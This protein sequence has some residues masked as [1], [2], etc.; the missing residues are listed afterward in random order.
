MN[1]S[2]T[3]S[4]SQSGF[5]LLERVIGTSITLVIITIASILLASSFAI[6]GREN[7]RSAA[8]ADAQRAG[9]VVALATGRMPAAARTFVDLLS[10]SGPQIFANGALVRTVSGE[11]LF[12]LPVEAAVARVG[13][14][15][16][17]VAH[18]EAPRA[19]ARL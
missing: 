3:K 6:R 7:Q 10:L 2:H 9:V 11:V 17:D 13:I 14:V 16:R 15:E 19:P 8:I 18:A 12:H 5:S 1:K 4:T